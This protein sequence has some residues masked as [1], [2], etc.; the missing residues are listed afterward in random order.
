MSNCPTHFITG[1]G[2]GAGL[3]LIAKRLNN[4]SIT[5]SDLIA[6]GLVSGCFS[7][8]PDI[9]EPAT[10]PT[11]RSLMHSLL[12]ILVT[13]YIQPLENQQFWNLAKSG[14]LS[15]LALDANT[16]AGLPLF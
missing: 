3:T 1:V 4:E 10:S 16:P 8:I 12:M 7:L 14:Y 9:L 11:H 5:F 13:L 6:A 15:H 2:V